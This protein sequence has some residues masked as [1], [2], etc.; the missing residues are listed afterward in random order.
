MHLLL[1]LVNGTKYFGSM[2]TSSLAR[3]NNKLLQILEPV[4][5]LYFLDENVTYIQQR[6]PDE[7]V[8]SVISYM[9][10]MFYTH[11]CKA[12]GPWT[13]PPEHISKSITMSTIRDINTTY[14]KESLLH[15]EYTD[16][17]KTPNR[18]SR[19]PVYTSINNTETPVKRDAFT[20]DNRHSPFQ[21]RSKG[22]DNNRVPIGLSG[23]GFNH[24]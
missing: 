11:G 1:R 16:L 9:L 5:Y 19:N 3:D 13:L 18:S 21:S 15:K 20:G 14:N 2:D 8:D 4:G 22:Y 6:V 23:K 10:E 17:L 24:K 7:A 12:C